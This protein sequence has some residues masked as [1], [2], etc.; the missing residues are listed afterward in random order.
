MIVRCTYGE[1]DYDLEAAK[2]ALIK[3]ADNFTL[4]EMANNAG[5]PNKP[6]YWYTEDSEAFM[7]TLQFFRS[8]VGQ[9]VIINSGYRQPEYNRK[10]GGASDSRHLWGQAADIRPLERFTAKDHIKAWAEAL[11]FTGWHGAINV[12]KNHEYYH[13]ETNEDIKNCLLIIRVYSTIGELA[14]LQT[15]EDNAIQVRSYLK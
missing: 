1:R 6:Q 15:I 9:R 2:P 10:I 12:Y 7:K 8:L 13:L 14:E 5:D 4:A 11:A 3:L